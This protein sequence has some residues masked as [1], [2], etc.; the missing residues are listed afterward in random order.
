LIYNGS[1]VISPAFVN[2]MLFYCQVQQRTG[3]IYL[4]PRIDCSRRE[5]GNPGGRYSGRNGRP[6]SSGN[7]LTILTVSVTLRPSVAGLGLAETLRRWLPMLRLRGFDAAAGGRR[8]QGSQTFG[9]VNAEIG[10]A[11]GPVRR[12]ASYY[13]RNNP[14]IAN[15]VAAIVSGAVGA[16]IK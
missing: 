11:A 4:A 15:G 7:L 3:Y 14:W 2:S 13:A 10:A 16:G 12:R 1:E 5:G 8:W 6:I 9:A